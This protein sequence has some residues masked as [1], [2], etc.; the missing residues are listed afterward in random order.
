MGI[1]VENDVDVE[2]QVVRPEEDTTPSQDQAPTPQ[3]KKD[4]VQLIVNGKEK[5]M[6]KTSAYLLDMMSD[7]IDN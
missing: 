6:H 5:K 4:G 3:I 2:D 1:V 7:D